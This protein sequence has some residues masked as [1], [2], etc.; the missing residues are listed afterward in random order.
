MTLPATQLP[1]LC[2]ALWH[3]QHI[4]FFKS[5]QFHLWHVTPAQFLPWN[6]FRGHSLG[7]SLC[8]D[9][10]IPS[11]LP[12]SQSLPTPGPMRARRL[13]SQHRAEYVIRLSQSPRVTDDLFGGQL[14]KNVPFLESYL[15][16]RSHPLG[17]SVTPRLAIKPKVA[18][19]WCP[20]QH[21]LYEM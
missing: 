7:R 13:F 8:W 4:L 1:I 17:E 19:Q 11:I 20:S 2:P 5:W 12:G 18:A 6:S 9:F 21:C 3:F 14:A 15:L 10:A 16:K